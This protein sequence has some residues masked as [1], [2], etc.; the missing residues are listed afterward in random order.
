MF[1]LS[2]FTLS[3]RPSKSASPLP[4]MVLTKRI[5]FSKLSKGATM[6]PTMPFS[7]VSELM[8]PSN[9]MLFAAIA[10]NRS[11]VRLAFSPTWAM[12]SS[13]PVASTVRS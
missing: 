11:P 13:S 10:F 4:A 8:M 2:S 5:D 7:V 12:M 1:A 9:T 3:V 6:S